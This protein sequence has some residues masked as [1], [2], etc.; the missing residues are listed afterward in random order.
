MVVIEILNPVSTV[1]WNGIAAIKWLLVILP[2]FYT[3]I[4]SEDIVK[5]TATNTCAV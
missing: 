3:K 4:K 5:P 1:S 2:S